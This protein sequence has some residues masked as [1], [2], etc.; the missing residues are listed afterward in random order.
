MKFRHVFALVP[1]CHAAGWRYAEVWRRHFYDGLAQAGVQ[2]TRPR[3]VD[4]AWA[5]PPQSFDP[6]RAAG[7]RTR[8]SEALL[9]Q[10]LGAEGSRPQA[11]ISCCFSHDLELELVD[12]VRAAGI[13]WVNFFCD[14]LYAFDWVSALAART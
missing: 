4:F 13:P 10:I 11:V 7:A 6:A 5:R 2:V 1:D 8:T 14:S 9:A 3:D 12:R